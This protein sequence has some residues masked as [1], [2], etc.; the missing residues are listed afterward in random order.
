MRGV[1]KHNKDKDGKSD[2]RPR[3][4]GIRTRVGHGEDAGAGEPQ[5]GMDL[6]FAVDNRPHVDSAEE[7]DTERRGKEDVQPLPVNTRPTTPRPCRIT[8]LDHKVLSQPI[9]NER[10]E[11]R[12]LARTAMMRWNIAPL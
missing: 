10:V 1:Q 11:T 4:V 8:S 9:V 5:L 6:V 7:R 3:T 2:V 12:A